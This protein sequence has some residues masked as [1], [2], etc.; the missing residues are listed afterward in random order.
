MSTGGNSSLIKRSIMLTITG[1]IYPHRQ[2]YVETAVSRAPSGRPDF[3]A[4]MFFLFYFFTSFTHAHP[5]PRYDALRAPIP[6]YPGAG[7]S[8]P[9][10]AVRADTCGLGPPMDLTL[11]AGHPTNGPQEGPFS[12]IFYLFIYLFI[13]SFRGHS[14][15][16]AELVVQAKVYGQ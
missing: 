15:W 2:V 4:P 11:L 3:R 7:Y 10:S 9:S 6:S 8:K 14:L 16:L 12:G 1:I 13:Y 5:P